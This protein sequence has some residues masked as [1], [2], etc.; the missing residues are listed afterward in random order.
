MARHDELL[1]EGAREAPEPLTAEQHSSR[2]GLKSTGGVIAGGGVVAAKA[3]AIGGLGKFFIWIF[4]WNSFSTAW[5]I[6][7]WI[8]IAVIAAI[9]L[10]WIVLRRRRVAA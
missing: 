6:G 3:G 1:E 7:G 10:T 2:L 8:A 4:F 9:G 5:R